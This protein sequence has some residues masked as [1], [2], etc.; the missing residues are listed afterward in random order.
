MRR[1]PT[2]LDG[3]VHLA[4]KVH[5]DSRGFFVEA[6]RHD[7]WA[8]HGVDLEF[9]QDNHSRSHQGVVRGM[10]FSLGDG[11]AK[12][13]RCARGRIWDVVV[14]LRAG[15]PT[16]GQHE[17][18]ELDDLDGH[19]LFV[20]VGFAHGFCVLSDLADV[21]YKVSSYYD[22]AVERGFRYDD[23]EV[24]I[25]WPTEVEHQV[26]ERD[27]TAPLLSEIAGDLTFSV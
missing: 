9:V 15:S 14:D 26:S 12:L 8:E 21:L 7:V 1:L 16:Y 4:P 27:A 11:Q 20:P 6:F 10:H 24:A 25:P 2:Q 23:P 17:A 18:F 5:G 22:P 3:L 13:V 19:Q